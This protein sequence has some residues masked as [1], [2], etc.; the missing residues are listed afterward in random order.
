[1]RL[2]DERSVQNQFLE[3]LMDPCSP[4]TPKY[5]SS[6]SCGNSDIR[7]SWDICAQIT[8]RKWLGW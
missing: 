7:T 1:M 4:A 2:T 8:D 5:S 6:N 3:G